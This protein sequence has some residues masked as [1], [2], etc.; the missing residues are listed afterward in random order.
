M[1]LGKFFSSKSQMNKQL[2]SRTTATPSDPTAISSLS[3][4]NNVIS[5]VEYRFRRMADA[6]DR[7]RTA[8]LATRGQ[9]PR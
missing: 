4:K 7:I 2:A 1:S 6:H 8:L 9:T 3:A 5:L